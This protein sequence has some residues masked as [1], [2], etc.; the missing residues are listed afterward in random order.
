MSKK[1]LNEFFNNRLSMYCRVS[2]EIEK[3]DKK[4]LSKMTLELQQK[5]KDISNYKPYNE[6]Y[7]LRKYKLS[8]DEFKDLWITQD[9]L[10]YCE[11]NKEI[12][13]KEIPG[14]YK[15]LQELSANYQQQFT[16]LKEQEEEIEIEK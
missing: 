9:F 6:F 3:N 16:V 7:D 11:S 2:N 12:I 8:E 1:R 4:A 13:K 10:Y 5:F 14:L 15:E